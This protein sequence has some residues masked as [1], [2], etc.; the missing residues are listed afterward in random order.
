VFLAAAHGTVRAYRTVKAVRTQPKNIINPKERTS[1]MAAIQPTA[2]PSAD[3]D[4]RERLTQQTGR[5]HDAL[6]AAIHQLEAALASAAPG[7]EHD[8][9]HRVDETLE[10]VAELLSQ[11]VSAADAPDGLL[12]EIDT[13]RP[14]LLHRVKRLRQ[15]HDDLLQHTKA[16]TSHVAYAGDEATPNFQDI[17]QRATWLLNALRHHQAAET[18]L[19]FETFWTDIGTVD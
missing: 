3:Q 16:L 14:T 18:D 1:R 6:L 7:R 10:G 9:R 2:T 13:L 11:H 12:A 15:E 5:E 4:R 8:W 19:V 17:R